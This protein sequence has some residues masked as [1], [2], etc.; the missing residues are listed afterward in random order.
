M[1]RGG[2]PGDAEDRG[3][4]GSGDDGGG[5]SGFPSCGLGWSLL[6]FIVAK[7]ESVPIG[8]DRFL[9]GERN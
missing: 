6:A 9:I 1:R 5:D 7:M 8:G 3:V 2:W 4:E